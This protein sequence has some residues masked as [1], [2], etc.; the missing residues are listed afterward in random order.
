MTNAACQKI[1]SQNPSAPVPDVTWIGPFCAMSGYATAAR[2]YIDA[3]ETASISVRVMDL[4]LLDTF[5]D[6]LLPSTKTLWARRREWL[7]QQFHPVLDPVTHQDV[8]KQRRSR[9]V[10]KDI[11]IIS[12][13]PRSTDGSRD[14]FGGIKARFPNFKRYIGYCTFESEPLPTGWVDSMKA[15]DEIWVPSQFNQRLFSR[16][17]DGAIPVRVLPHGV[18]L[19]PDTIPRPPSAIFTFLSVFQC[20]YHKGFDLLLRA[21]GEAFRGRD[22]VQLLLHTNG[23][24]ARETLRQAM[25]AT[26]I[27]SHE[28]PPVLL[29][30]DYLSNSLM[31]ELYAGCDAFV[32]PTRGEGWGLPL[33]EAMAFGLPVIGSACGGTTD[34]LTEETGWPIPC[35]LLRREQTLGCMQAGQIWAEPDLGALVE[36]L[37]TVHARGPEVL[38]RCR[39]ARTMLA[40]TYSPCAIGQ[41][42]LSLLTTPPAPDTP[43]AITTMPHSR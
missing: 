11:L 27:P 42:L 23:D 5:W 2:Y 25:D 9:R 3:A 15:M 32:L 26:G 29:S 31:G 28:M 12:S 4:H 30:T 40:E 14:L 6:E 36:S 10:N 35:R 21:F 1:S 20:S 33:M 19:P 41:K 24:G 43:Q 8:W 17:L 39:Q 34:F 37:R 22:D 18:R 13:L 16:E 38:R 7:Q